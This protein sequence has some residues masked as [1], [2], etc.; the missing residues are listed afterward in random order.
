MRAIPDEF[1][2]DS[3]DAIAIHRS[4]VGD[5]ELIPPMELQ[6]DHLTMVL[7]LFIRKLS[8]D[9]AKYYVV[10]L[11]ADDLEDAYRIHME[12]L[13][14]ALGSG[15]QLS[16]VHPTWFKLPKTLADEWFVEPMPNVSAKDLYAKIH[17]TI[18]PD[19][20]GD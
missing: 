13:R 14:L 2:F 20:A 15:L 11:A 4:R 10:M 8:S 3:S 12:V 18:C 7:M 17:R 5:V 6:E 19:K 1:I 16:F 9:G